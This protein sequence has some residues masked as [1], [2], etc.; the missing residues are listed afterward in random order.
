MDKSRIQTYRE[1]IYKCFCGKGTTVHYKKRSIV[2]SSHT[3]SQ[4]IYLVKSGCI[5]QNFIDYNGNEK[6]LLLLKKGDLF[7][8]ITYFNGDNNQVITK[9]VADSEL[10]KI[11]VNVFE[12]ISFQKPMINY[13]I[14]LMLSNKF[15]IVMAQL[16]DSS[17]CDA[18]DRLKNLLIRLSYQQG[19]KVKNGIKIPHHFTHEDLAQMISS[20]RSTVTR[21][22][23]VLEKRGVIEIKKNIIVK[24][25]EQNKNVRQ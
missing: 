23:K 10:E 2:D 9:A 14:N 20:T 6:I 24:N 21:K 15:R 7:G 5:E 16:K 17:F 19:E 22:L 4:Y 12:Q 3:V 18:E 25:T 11:P 13:Y 1:E 8:E